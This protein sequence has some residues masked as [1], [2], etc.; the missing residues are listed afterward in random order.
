MTGRDGGGEWPLLWLLCARAGEVAV[1][2][3]ASANRGEAG[4][5]E[6]GERGAGADTRGRLVL[7]GLEPR[8]E[9]ERLGLCG[10]QQR[11]PPQT[12]AGLGSTLGSSILGLTSTWQVLFQHLLEILL[13]SPWR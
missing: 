4:R 13:S 6:S 11:A 8:A 10:E 7:G 1:L 5:P 3:R 9:G 12:Q 2:A